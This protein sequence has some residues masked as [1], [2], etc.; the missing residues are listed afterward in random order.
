MSSLSHA[1]LEEYVTFK[2]QTQHTLPFCVSKD[3][4]NLA[5]VCACDWC[6]LSG[7]MC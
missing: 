4:I 5:P 6:V 7:G 1:E 2:S 3:L